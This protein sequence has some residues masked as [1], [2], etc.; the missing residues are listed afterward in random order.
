VVRSAPL[1]QQSSGIGD[2]G[3]FR[4]DVNERGQERVQQAEGRHQHADAIYDQ[5]AIEVLHDKVKN[6]PIKRAA[7]SAMV[8]DNS[9]VILRSQMS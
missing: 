8:M 3:K 9:I 7:T 2:K 5:G 6:S 4:T 1:G